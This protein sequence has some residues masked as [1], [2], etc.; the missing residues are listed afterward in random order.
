MVDH[1]AKLKELRK[2]HSDAKAE[3]IRLS[4]KLEESKERRAEAVSKIKEK[5]YEVKEL[6]TVIKDKEEELEKIYEEIEA[7]LPSQDADDDDDE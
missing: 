2:R 4:T 3:E 1:T 5:G 6:K 7:L